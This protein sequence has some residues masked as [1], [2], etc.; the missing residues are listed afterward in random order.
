VP[1]RPRLVLPEYP[2][3]V[4]QRGVNRAAIFIDDVDRQHY[5]RLLGRACRKQSVALHAFVLM[6][7]HV[8][9]LLTPPISAALALAMKAAGQS[10]VRYFNTRHGRSGTLWEGRY[11]SCLV[12]TDRYFLM[13]LR[14]IELNPVRAALVA[15]PQDH[16]WSSVHTHLGLARH[17][18]LTPHPVYLAL[19]ASAVLRADGY[20]RFLE[21]G[22]PPEEL[23][24][25]QNY[26]RQER[27]LGGTRF[28]KMVAQ[29][30]NRTSEFRTPGRPRRERS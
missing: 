2:F 11:K 23:E 15:A 16:A 22:I 24:N 14:Y 12:D 28:Q 3:H 4:I 6:G 27:A 19:G 9:L 17:P 8:H 29:T 25:I 26:V 10:Y 21:A 18:L 13:V 5:C 1:R 30:L 7:N 20:R